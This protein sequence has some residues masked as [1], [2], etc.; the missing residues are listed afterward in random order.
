M[1]DR[2]GADHNKRRYSTCGDCCESFPA[3]TA[4]ESA[5]LCRAHVDAGCAKA[6]IGPP[7]VK[8]VGDNDEAH[9]W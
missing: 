5:D 3:A 4:Q 2:D 7:G 9:L 6:R 1:H 8:V